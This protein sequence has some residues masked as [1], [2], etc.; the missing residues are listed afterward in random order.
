MGRKSQEPSGSARDAV[1]NFAHGISG[2]GKATW[3]GVK[4]IYNEKIKPATINKAK[5][6]AEPTY[7][8]EK[9]R[10]QLNNIEGEIK[11]QTK[12]KQ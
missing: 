10:S 1:S 8:D 11:C 9:Q 7:E 4:W 12:Q 2:V 3:S 6:S 5:T